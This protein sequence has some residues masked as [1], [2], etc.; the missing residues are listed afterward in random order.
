MSQ[1]SSLTNSLVRVDLMLEVEAKQLIRPYLP[2]YDDEEQTG[3]SH[4]LPQRFSDNC[5][6]RIIHLKSENTIADYLELR[7]EM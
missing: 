5:T 6:S 3:G 4:N 2:E 1:E 7:Q